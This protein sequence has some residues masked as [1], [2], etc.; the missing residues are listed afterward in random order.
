MKDEPRTITVTG[1]PVVKPRYFTESSHGAADA[2]PSMKTL[3]MRHDRSPPP[4]M[5]HTPGE[6]GDPNKG[7]RVDFEAIDHS[8]QAS[9]R[10]MCSALAVQTERIQMSAKLGGLATTEIEML[11]RLATIWRTLVQNEP[12]PDVSKMS[13]EELQGR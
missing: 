9:H 10:K 13:D 4:S 6:L 1:D 12:L 11:S 3:P 7:V 5:R 8:L 2:T